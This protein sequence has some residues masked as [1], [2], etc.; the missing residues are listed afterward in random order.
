MLYVDCVSLI[1][2]DQT[3]SL[4]PHFVQKRESDNYTALHV[5]H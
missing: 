4:L 2:F 1:T 3:F 5:G